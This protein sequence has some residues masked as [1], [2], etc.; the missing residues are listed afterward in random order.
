MSKRTAICVGLAAITLDR[1]GPW[2]PCIGR[3]RCRAKLGRQVV[4]R[5][6]WRPRRPALAELCRA[7]IS[8]ISGGALDYRIFASRAAAI[9]ARDDAAHHLHARADGRHH[10][11]H[12]VVEAAP[13][14]MARQSRLR[15]KIPS[16]RALGRKLPPCPKLGS[17][18]CWARRASSFPRC[19][20]PPSLR[21]SAPNMCWPC[22][23]WP[24]EMPKTRAPRRQICGRTAKPAASQ[25]GGSIASL[26]AV[27]RSAR[28]FI[29]SPKLPV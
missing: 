11:L 18:R 19:S 27:R 2:E 8:G 7:D 15:R 21:T 28:E 25:K 13:L 5:V 12:N 3:S 23:R 16:P 17:S 26:R 29:T 9:T 22:F 1:T 4:R 6:S 24:P 14:M 10:R 20:M